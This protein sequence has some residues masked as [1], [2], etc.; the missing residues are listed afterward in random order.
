MELI[1]WPKVEKSTSSAKNALEMG[2]TLY[3]VQQ[4]IFSTCERKRA[5]DFKVPDMYYTGVAFDFG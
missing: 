3:M 1:K 5:D 2:L 4:T